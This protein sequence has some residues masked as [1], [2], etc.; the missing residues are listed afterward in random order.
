[1]DDALDIAGLYQV[2]KRAL[3]CSLNYYSG[4]PEAGGDIIDIGLAE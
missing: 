4:F 3:F 2:G 1:V